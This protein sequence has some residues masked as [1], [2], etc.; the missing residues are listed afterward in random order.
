MRTS[1]F[2]SLVILVV[3]SSSL[4]VQIDGYCYLEGE[5]DHSGI[6]IVFAEA[7]P[8]AVTDSVYTN[9]S[10]DYQLD[11]TP[12]LYDVYYSHD[13]FNDQEIIG[14]NCFDPIT[15]PD[16]TLPLMEGIPI[17]G[18]QSGVLAG[19]TYFVV[20]DLSIIGGESL[21]IEPG[22]VFL[23][24]GDY[25]F[26][27]GS[28]R[29][30]LCQGTETDSIKFMPNYDGGI[31]EWGGIDFSSSGSDDIL[32]FCLITG[33]T[34]S[35]I[36]CED[37]SPTI[38]Y[39]TINGN[40]GGE[41]GGGIYC[42]NSS[43]TIS[44]C[45]ISGNSIHSGGGIYCE[46]SSPTIS[47]CTISGNL[48]NIGGGI[49][50]NWDSN[51]TINNCTISENSAGAFGGGIYCYLSSP[52][53]S[54]CAVTDNMG[55]GIHVDSGSPDIIY[56]DFYNNSGGDF[57]GG[58]IN[59]N[60]G[61]IVTTNANG[62]PCDGFLNIFLDPLYVNPNNGNYHLQETSPCIDAGDPTSPLDPDG[63]VADI[64]VFYFDHLLIPSIEVTSPAAGDTWERGSS[65]SIT[66][67]DNID[68]NVIIELYHGLTLEEVIAEDTE[69]DGS[70]SWDIPS[71]GPL[72]SNY[73]IKIA[74]VVDE[75]I[76]D[77]SDLFTLE[78]TPPALLE[79]YLTADDPLSVP[80]GG[81]FSYN[82]L[83][84]S[85][86]P[87]LTD[88]DI[89]TQ[90]IMPNSNPYGPIWQINDFPMMPGGSIE[91]L[92]IGQDIPMI[93]PLG[94]YSFQIMA[95]TYPNI[96][97]AQDEFPFEIV[98]AGAMTAGASDWSSS[99]YQEAFDS[100][101]LASRYEEIVLPDSYS[102][103]AAYPNPFNPTT[104]ISVA[105]PNAADLAVVVYNVA[106]QQVAE[107]ANGQFTAGTHNLTFDA[108]GIASGLY[109][110]RASVPGELDKV[111]KVMLVR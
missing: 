48:S 93:A 83:L 21:T 64:G 13:G 61:V 3:A 88:V 5:V 35:G 110:V 37:S 17:S 15:L 55:E 104:T 14:Q 108:S 57:G 27:I 44:Y 71:E 101:Q 107:L 76:F 89:W 99:G 23:F 68:E 30:L 28:N 40:S 8:T 33:S 98:A 45:T 49:S 24:E 7:S 72:D 81:E 106:G 92:G 2:V 91:A 47:H 56:G 109:F 60:L 41:G 39:C 38:S 52:T 73:M 67:T 34:T 103:S 62:D 87:T 97:V 4:S 82:A 69:S 46:G 86:L 59:P 12:G 31:T 32:E 102:I 53:I 66:W 10:G 65:Y 75:N 26:T 18:L 22:A 96:I 63:T 84:I 58:S 54:N 36:Y 77:D 100:A 11:V 9:T 70:Y 42:Y 78:N 51:P 25:L 16:V 74:S 43:P 19:V 29:T 1:L 20:G 111:Q 85:N 95:G 105:L 94:V 80:R 50:C 90:V 79:V 6:K